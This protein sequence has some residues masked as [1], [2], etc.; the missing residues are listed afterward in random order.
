MGVYTAML[1]TGAL[2][3]I[4]LTPRLFSAFGDWRP[5]LAVWAIPALVAA[6]MSVPLLADNQRPQ[7]HVPGMGLWRI[8]L[9]WAVATYMGLQS[10]TFYAVALWLGSLLVARGFS[11]PAVAADLTVFYFVQFLAALVAP[12]ILTKARRQDIIAMFFA[13]STGALIIAVLYGPPATTFA[14]CAALGIGMGGLFGVALTFQVLRA[15]ST[16]NVARLSSMSLFIGYCIASAGPLVLGLV[17]HTAD[18]RLASALW[19]TAIAVLTM[20]AGAFA[21][22]PRFVDPSS[23]VGQS[24]TA[25]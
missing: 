9:A 12:V 21:G 24:S 3:G 20:I 18:A 17:N 2:I 19:L 5:T 22:R 23:S 11:L 1:A 15:R 16:D 13:G 6:L 25:S 4:T 7:D 8:P 10:A 14:F